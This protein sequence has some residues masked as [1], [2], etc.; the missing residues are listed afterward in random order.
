MFF[1]CEMKCSQILSMFE[2]YRKS[3]EEEEARHSESIFKFFEW[4][5]CETQHPPK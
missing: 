2:A 3:M 4:D 1:E 5:G